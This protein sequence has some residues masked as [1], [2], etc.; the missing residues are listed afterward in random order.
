MRKEIIEAIAN[1]IRLTNVKGIRMTDL[2]PHPI[3]MAL[4]DK[5]ADT[6]KILSLVGFIRANPDTFWMDDSD[7]SNPTI[8]CQEDVDAEVAPD[9]RT[10]EE[11]I[12]D[13]RAALPPGGTPVTLETF[14]AWKE[15]REAQRL[16]EEE[17]ESKEKAKKAKSK[18]FVGLSGRDL[19]TFDASL[20]ADDEDAVDAEE[21]DERSEPEEEEEETVARA[22]KDEADEEEDDEQDEEGGV[23]AESGAA[24]SGDAAPAEAIN[25]SL[26]LGGGELPDDLDDLDDDDDQT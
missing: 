20:F 11:I 26:F 21:Y 25:E 10:I 2:G 3:L 13:K 5:Y 8:R 24:G 15:R 17:E 16:A 4:K 12:E 23:A 9:D 6:F 1:T 22:P 7:S 14:K 19:F 18:N